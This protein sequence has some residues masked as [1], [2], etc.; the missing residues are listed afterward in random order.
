MKSIIFDTGP[1]ISLVTNNLLWILKPLKEKFKGDFYITPAVKKELIDKALSTKRFEFEALQI[2]QLINEGTLKIIETSQMRILSKKLIDMANTSFKAKGSWIKIVSEAE[3][4]VLAAD[5]I[6]NADA[7]VIDER[8]V[9]LL[10]ENS[11]NLTNLMEERLHCKVQPNKDNIKEFKKQL[12]NVQIIRSTELIVVA[13]K[14]GILNNL[15][16]DK[17]ELV[18]DPRKTLLDAALWAVKVRGCSISSDEIR[19]IIRLE[20]K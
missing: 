17:S 6:L 19:E 2:S 7:A 14:L 16:I 1:I 18:K 15:L 5:A 12:E 4:E 8:T 10:L 20:I 3:V 11:P 13:Y 9:R